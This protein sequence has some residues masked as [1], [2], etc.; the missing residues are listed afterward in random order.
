MQLTRTSQSVQHCSIIGL[1][2]GRQFTHRQDRQMP[3]IPDLGALRP[4]ELARNIAD[5]CDCV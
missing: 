1:M 5:L 3:E 4:Q 2:Y